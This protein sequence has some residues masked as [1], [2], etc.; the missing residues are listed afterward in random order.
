MV[1]RQT[2]PGNCSFQ[3][4]PGAHVRDRYTPSLL[5]ERPLHWLAAL[6]LHVRTLPLLK[7]HLA[8]IAVIFDFVNP[9]IPLWGLL[10][11]RRELWLDETESANDARHG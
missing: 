2:K 8:A 11:E 4:R 7:Q 5:A 3:G 9:V 10:D 1:R 6:I